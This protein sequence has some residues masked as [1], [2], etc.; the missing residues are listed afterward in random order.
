MLSDGREGKREIVR[1]PDAAA[2]LPVDDKGNVH[3]VRQVRHAVGRTLI[4]VPA[5]LLNDGENESDAARRECEEETGLYTG[6]LKKLLYYAH[7]EGYS[8][9]F[10][11]LF[12]GTKLSYTGK[13]NMD[14]TEFVEP[15]CLQYRDL[16]ELMRKNQIIDSKT[17]LCILLTR[18]WFASHFPD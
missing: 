18:E 6:E 17:I 13:T 10:I 14:E 1:V 4:E 9:G 8:T 3:L 11:T 12:L 16:V 15:V 2:V 7:A 5:G